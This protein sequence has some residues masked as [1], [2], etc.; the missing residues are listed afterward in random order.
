MDTANC[1]MVASD[2]TKANEILAK[3]IDE[4]KE[5]I[6]ELMGVIQRLG[7]FEPRNE[8]P[9]ELGKKCGEGHINNL[10]NNSDKIVEVNESL[11]YI[12]VNLNRMV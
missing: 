6:Q 1:A 5:L 7:T 4:T 8:A 2:F 10:Y 11:N 9:R 12:L 3:R